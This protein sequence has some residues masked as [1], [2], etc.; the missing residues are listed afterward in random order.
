M[1]NLFAGVGIVTTIRIL[2]VGD[3]DKGSLTCVHW[4][5]ARIQSLWDVQCNFWT[6]RKRDENVD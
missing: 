1:L 4:Y 5:G 6:Q 2:I 3:T